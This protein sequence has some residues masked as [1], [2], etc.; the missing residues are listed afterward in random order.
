MASPTVLAPLFAEWPQLVGSSLAA[1]VRP[2]AL[3]DGVLTVEVDDQAWVA[4][5]RFLEGDLVARLNE[6]LGPDAVK[7]VVVRTPRP[8]ARR[9]RRSERAERAER[10]E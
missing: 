1:A 8:G 5:L 4:Q 3:A 6:R 10:A 2:R 7:S 9:Y